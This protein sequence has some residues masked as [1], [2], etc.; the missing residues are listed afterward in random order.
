MRYILK[1][2]LRIHGIPALFSL[3]LTLLAALSLHFSLNLQF[4][5]DGFL[6]A[7]SLTFRNV[8]FLEG[9]QGLITTAV[10]LIGVGAFVFFAGAI[11][12][13]VRKAQM[14]SVIRGALIVFYGLA[15]F[16]AYGVCRITALIFEKN[17]SLGA[18]TIRTETVFYWR[19]DFLWPVALLAIVMACVHVFAWRRKVIDLYTGYPE[20]MPAPGDRIVENIRTHGRDPL[21]RKS[22]I[23]SILIHFT[24]IVLIPF[25]ARFGGCGRVQPYLIPEGSGNPVIG[26]VKVVKPKKQMKKRIVLN[27]HSAISFH[28]PN[29]DDSSVE[30][31]VDE[32]TLQTYV[33]DASSVHQS[34]GKGGL[35]AGGGGKGGWPG[36]MKN[37]IV[38]FIRLEYDGEGWN[39][40]MEPSFRSD[41]NFL[42]EFKK[43]TGFKIASNGESH[44]IRMLDDYPKGFAP[45][46]VFMCGHGQINVSSRDIE[47]LRKYLLDGGM[48][49]ADCGSVQWDRNFRAFIQAVLPGEQLVV[50]SKDDPLYQMPNVF[51]DGAPP[52]WHHGGM[53]ALGIKRGSRWM[54]YYHPG[55]IHDAW[56]IGHSGMSPELTRQA[57]QLGINIVYHAF[58]HYLEATRKYRK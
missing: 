14:L 35:G 57:Y 48:L 16:Y 39:D 6:N 45:P 25:M 21:F 42:D 3:A 5:Y 8:F 46:F 34:G 11:L 10:V 13:L 28:P 31:D 12:S 18:K 49:F 29:L 37:A 51:A 36:G 7:Q 23:Y 26:I 50:I 22:V 53:Q 1:Q 2:F 43:E 9:I 41:M 27:P 58:T 30:Q 47:I 24:V 52:F 44:S 40:G 32:S 54:V 19:Y 20:D 56:K 55:D 33:A 15:L 38:R 4:Y 17:L